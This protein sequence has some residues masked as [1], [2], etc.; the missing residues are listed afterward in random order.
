ML[1]GMTILLHDFL[2][3]VNQIMDAQSKGEISITKTNIVIN[4]PFVKIK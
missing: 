3:S 2:K 4:S 1:N